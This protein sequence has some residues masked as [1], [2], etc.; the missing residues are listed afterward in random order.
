[1]AT[2]PNLDGIPQAHVVQTPSPLAPGSLRL[3]SV[4][5][6]RGLIMVVM[7]LDHVRDYLTHLQFAP[8]DVTHTYLALWITRWVTH[9]CAPGFFFLAGTG[10]FLSYARGKSKARISRFLWTRGLWLVLLECTVIGFAWTFIFPFPW[11]GVIWALGWCMVANAAIVRLPTKWVAAIGAL[12][13]LGHN[14]LDKVQPVGWGNVPWY[15]VIF[16]QPGFI[17]LPRPSG[18]NLPIPQGAPFGLFILY[19]LIPWIGV[20]ALGFAF[21][22][23]LRRPPADRQRWMLRAGGIMTA[24]FIVLRAFNLYGNPVHLFAAGPMIDAR[25][26]LLPSFAQDF[27]LLTDVE[28]Y[29]PSLQF[30]LMTLGPS[31][32]AMA[33]FDKLRD[34]DHGPGLLNAAARFFVAYGRVP[35]FYYVLHLY[36]IHLMAIA[37]ASAFGQPHEHLWRGGFMLFGVP[38]GFGFNLPFIYLVWVVAV[39]ILYYPCRWFMGVKQRRRDWWLSYI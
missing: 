5:I 15:W 23:I 9:F 34:V 6:L 2:P 36:L 35:M 30:L 12:M 17:P 14:L 18:V 4:D 11:G 8:E 16:H 19:P 28:K 26:H 39:L 3:D 20:M 13:V 21:G 25:F 22:E 1:M 37:V 33:C 27:I 38:P 7:A 10:A 32:I 29:P 24:A 31:L